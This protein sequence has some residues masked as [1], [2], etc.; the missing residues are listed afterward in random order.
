MLR[1]KHR[2]MAVRN[3]LLQDLRLRFRSARLR[4][5]VAWMCLLAFIVASQGLMPSAA[6]LT[7]LGVLPVSGERYPCE[8]CACGC[9]SA[10]HCWTSC[11]C[12]TLEE[13]VDW[14][15]ANNVAIPRSIA[16]SAYKLVMARAAAA[17]LPAC[18][19]ARAMQQHEADGDCHGACHTA[20]DAS[21]SADR[22]LAV[23]MATISAL[24]CK[25]ISG[26]LAV[27]PPML[28][29]AFVALTLPRAVRPSF[30]APIGDAL[31]AGL[32]IEH[33]AP[34]PRA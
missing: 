25:G 11:C 13:R 23:R 3:R 17:E 22:T 27:A 14:A 18:C 4:A 21:A 1:L 19:A 20:R 7:R 32:V 10:E 15:I 16:Q 28:P 29:N 2:L 8:G 5:V 12:H 34:P 6:L 33:P 24:G 26:W 30:G 9:G 31:P